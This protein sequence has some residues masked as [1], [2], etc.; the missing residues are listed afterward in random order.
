LQINNDK[1]QLKNVIV[2]TV[3]TV[4]WIFLFQFRK[5]KM[6]ALSFKQV[7]PNVPHPAEAK[8]R[9]L[10]IHR[11]TQFMQ[12]Q[13]TLELYRD[14]LRAARRATLHWIFLKY[15][16]VTPYPPPAPSQTSLGIRGTT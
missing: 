13:K 7:R 3:K 2:K 15:R 16:C 6:A 8:P 11:H 5:K 14:I 1:K 10:S 12:K 4:L 9:K